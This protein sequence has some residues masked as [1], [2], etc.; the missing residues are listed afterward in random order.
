[1]IRQ[2]KSLDEINRHFSAKYDNNDN[3]EAVADLYSPLSYANLSPAQKDYFET[4]M[5]EKYLSGSRE[6]KFQTEKP[7][8]TDQQLRALSRKHLL[9]MIR[10]LEKE[11][12]QAKE[13]K[14]NLLLACK[15]NLKINNAGT[16]Q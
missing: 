5:I 14:E 8:I 2:I 10:D 1:M 13:E 11:L 7:K 16:G 4:L 3:S 6:E 12:K 9:M 15:A